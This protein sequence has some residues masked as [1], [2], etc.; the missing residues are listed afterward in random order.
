MGPVVATAMIH[1]DRQSFQS[2]KGTPRSRRPPRGHAVA[3][4]FMGRQTSSNHPYLLTILRPSGAATNP[5]APGFDLSTSA[6]DG[7]CCR[8]ATRDGRR[9]AVATSHPEPPSDSM[10]GQAHPPAPTLP[11]RLADSP[12]LKACRREPAGVTPIW[13]MRQAGRYMAE[14]R[15]VRGP[16]PVPGTLQ[17]ARTGHRGHGHGRRT[18]RRRRRHPLRRHP[19]DPRTAR[20]PS[21]IREGGR[22]D[23]PQPHPVG[24]RRRPH[25]PPR[26][27][28]PTRLR[29]PGRPRDPGR[30]P[31]RSP[32]HR[33]RRSTLHPGVLR[34]RRSD[35]L[36]ITS[37]PRHS[38]M[39]ILGPGI[40]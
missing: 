39:A 19:P 9:P 31:L 1:F 25:P 17:A 5:R 23:H 10:N 16:R 4:G 6:P 36:G 24:G 21:R 30:P 35:L 11:D 33:L 7:V 27:H 18:P 12:F 38:C 20:L 15:E 13:L 22:P 32:P 37:G 26:R 40:R 8:I 14:Y 29:L 2:K 28:L 3:S 34:H